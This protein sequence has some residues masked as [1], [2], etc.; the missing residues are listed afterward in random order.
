V[1]EPNK[2]VWS[3]GGTPP[4]AKPAPGTPSPRPE[5]AKAAA[6]VRVR[7]ER[8]G[9]GGKVVTVVDGLPGHPAAIE[10][11]ARA[12]KSRCGAGGTVKG[13]VVEIQGD[14]RDKVVALLVALG[15]AAKRA[16]G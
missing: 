4:T 7:L 5:S 9:R 16:G 3:A 8:Q 1:S 12:L 10:E 11:V 2:I 15:H 6:P 13:R 14:H